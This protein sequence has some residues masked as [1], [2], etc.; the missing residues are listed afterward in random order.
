MAIEA[1]PPLRRVEILAT[2][3][4]NLFLEITGRR[5]D[6]F[7]LLDS[8]VVFADIGDLVTVREGAGTAQFQLAATGP[9]ADRLPRVDDDNLVIAA[10]RRLAGAWPDSNDKDGDGGVFEAR[11]A[12]IDLVKNLPVSAGIGGGSV[13][14]AA[15]L[16]GLT[17][18][19]THDGNTPIDE[20]A[21]A[22]LALALGADVPICLRGEPAFMR[23]IGEAIT[24]A[25]PIPELS[26]LLINPGLPLP[27]PEVFA[28]YD[29]AP[30]NYSQPLAIPD[31]FGGPEAFL[32]YIGGRKNDLTAAACEAMPVIGEILDRIGASDGC[33][34]ARM[35]G[36]GA[37]CFGLYDNVGAA[38][39]ARQ[40]LVDH[41]S[42]WWLSA[43]KL[44][45]GALPTQ[46]Y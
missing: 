21:M 40:A 46:R 39:Q 24:P 41:G 31:A 38:Q 14:A 6:G 43:G 45:T 34:L 42:E 17:A 25:P 18:L 11:R 37:T 12:T 26:I 9:F 4:V 2:A 16:R 5:Q 3:K 44:L 10:A 27:T 22:E 29:E 8:L 35:S 15:T 30:T 20:N 19:W 33:R 13:D 7:H 23:G 28:R 1:T 36:S 32:T